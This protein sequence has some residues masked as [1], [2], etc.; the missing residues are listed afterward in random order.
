MSF[1]LGISRFLVDFPR[2]FSVR[3]RNSHPDGLSRATEVSRSS[4]VL[5]VHVGLLDSWERMIFGSKECKPVP[6][7][8]LSMFLGVKAALYA[9]QKS[10]QKSFSLIDELSPVS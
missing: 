2:I 5:G 10:Y 7:H 3:W 6:F 4:G 8:L 9:G 1:R